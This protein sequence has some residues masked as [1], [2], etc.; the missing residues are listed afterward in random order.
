MP[1][2]SDVTGPPASYVEG[3][4]RDGTPAG[5]AAVRYAQQLARILKEAIGDRSIRE[6]A[7]QTGIAHTTIAGVLN[8]SRWADLVTIARLEETLETKLWPDIAG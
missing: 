7:R 2:R 6:I 3:P 1:R 8:G 4:F 5:P